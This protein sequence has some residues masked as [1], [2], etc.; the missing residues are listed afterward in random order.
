MESDVTLITSRALL[1]ELINTLEKPKLQKHILAKQQTSRG[2]VTR[3]MKMV[4]FVTPASLGT[5]V[6]RDPDDDAV[7]EAAIGGHA[8]VIVSGDNDL[9][10]I[11]R[12]RKVSILTAAELIEKLS[13]LDN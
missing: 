7:L 9:L 2:I 4:E 13:E 5:S 6:A 8:D 12:F 3:Y 1:R 10:T 11:G